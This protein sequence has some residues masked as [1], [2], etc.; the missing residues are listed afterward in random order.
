MWVQHFGGGPPHFFSTPSQHPHGRGIFRKNT[1]YKRQAPKQ[2]GCEARP[3]AMIWERWGP[4]FKGGPHALDGS[5]Y[6]EKIRA[7]FCRRVLRGRVGCWPKAGP[8]QSSRR[9]DPQGKSTLERQTGQK[10]NKNQRGQIIQATG[11]SA[12]KPWGPKK[13]WISGRGLFRGQAARTCWH[14]EARKTG[15]QA[16]ASTTNIKIGPQK[17]AIRY[18]EAQKRKGKLRTVHTGQGCFSVGLC[19]S[20]WSS[21]VCIGLCGVSIRNTGTKENRGEKKEMAPRIFC[22]RS[23]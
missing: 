20:P 10:G 18:T 11:Y 3:G 22:L 15:N 4:V 16:S 6:D 12:R 17:Q 13:S 23:L 7:L 1:A 14:A 5:D 21:S 8:R 2:G 19:S 9:K